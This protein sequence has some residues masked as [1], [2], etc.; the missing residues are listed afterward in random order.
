M[1]DIKSLQIN[2][3]VIL[4]DPHGSNLDQ[5][6]TVVN[7]IYQGHKKRKKRT[8]PY[9]MTKYTNRSASRDCSGTYTI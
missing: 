8:K 3:F 9:Q 7:K 1:C 4:E 5:H 6:I 2:L